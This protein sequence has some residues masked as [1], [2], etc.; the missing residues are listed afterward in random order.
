[1][2]AFDYF[3]PPSLVMAFVTHTLIG[4]LWYSPL[5]FGDAFIKLAHPKLRGKPEMDYNALMA[6]M[7]GS[8]I[9][10]PV[11]CFLFSYVR[12]R[13]GGEGALWGAAIALFFDAGLNSSYNLWENRPFALFVMH[14]GYHAF[15][16]LVIG[17]LLGFLCG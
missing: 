16:L 17:A 2:A 13:S 8:A 7:I 4:A 3:S 1:M 9:S 12:P 6:A 15:S 14:A 10:M 11:L 5:F